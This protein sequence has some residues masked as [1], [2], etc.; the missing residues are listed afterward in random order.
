[1]GQSVTLFELLLQIGLI[2]DSL[3]QENEV[4]IELGDEAVDGVWVFAI[5]VVVE[6][7]AGSES[8]KLVD[9]CIVS[10]VGKLDQV[11]G[12]KGR[13]EDAD[14]WELPLIGGFVPEEENI[15]V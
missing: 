8:D 12:G 13:C 6:G 15:D 2:D 5:F 4:V 7:N 1:M 9:Q 3:H 10:E 11:I 14:G